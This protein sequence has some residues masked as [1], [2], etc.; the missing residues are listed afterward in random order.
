MLRKLYFENILF[1][2][3]FVHMSLV[4]VAIQH[5]LKTLTKNKLSRNSAIRLTEGVCGNNLK[6]KTSPDLGFLQKDKLMLS[7]FT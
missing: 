3:I 7:F 6:I 4:P 2:H 1:F 5:Y